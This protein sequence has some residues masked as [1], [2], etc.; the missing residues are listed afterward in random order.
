MR[1]PWRSSERLLPTS[2]EGYDIH[3]Y[4]LNNA[5]AVYESIRWKPE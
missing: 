1:T 4:T 3:F 2:V 5:Q